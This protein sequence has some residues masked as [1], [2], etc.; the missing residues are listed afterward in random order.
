MDGQESVQ[1]SPVL[2]QVSRTGLIRFCSPPCLAVGLRSGCGQDGMGDYGQGAVP[3]RADA[4]A[5]LLFSE[6]H[7]FFAA[8]KHSSTSPRELA[9][10]TTPANSIPTSEQARW[11]AMSP[12]SERLRRAI[13]QR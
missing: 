2:R 11:W 10:R 5:D 7:S 4:A 1:K 8:W 12:G 6:P 9:I 3:V 13:T